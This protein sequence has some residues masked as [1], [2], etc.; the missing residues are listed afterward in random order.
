MTTRRPLPPPALSALPGRH[1]RRRFLGLAGA[2]AAGTA[3]GACRPAPTGG[4]P[5]GSDQVQLVYQD[6]R[7]EWFPAM[8][9]KE[10]ETFQQANPGIRV[11]Y[12]P[13]PDNIT[14][15][16]LADMQAGTAPDVLN[17]CCETLPAWA[18]QGYLL[19]LGPYIAAD[20]D[21]ATILDWDPAQYDALATREGV[22]FALPKYH[23]AL[24]LFYNKD[25][26]DARGVDHPDRGWT[27][28]D[29]LEA[30]KRVSSGTEDGGDGAVWG[31]MCDISWDR[32]QVYVN[33]FGGHLVDPEDPTRSRMAEPESLAGMEWL[34]ARM[35]DDRV[36]A[37]FL[38]VNNLETREAF[39]RGHL[40]MVEDGSW[41][42]K[43]ILENADFRVGVTTLPAGPV[44]RVTLATTDGFAIY[45]GTKHPEAAWELLK[46]LAGREYG[47]AMARTHLL[48][49][50]RSSL[51]EEW[52][53]TIREAY[54]RQAR[55]MDIEAFAE[56][57]V[58]GYSVTAEIF[59]NMTA[60]RE[61]A[62]AAW[63]EIFTLGR[64]PVSRM[65]AVSAEIEAAQRLGS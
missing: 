54:P 62:G 15:R 61:I 10:L 51:I 46:F 25:V 40:A 26:F 2:A 11:F 9:Q 41:A 27:H 19:D 5:H 47:R 13:D 53:A 50:A 1:S 21:Q 17:G 38:D 24:A 34:R 12:T 4:G 37:S 59:A 44:R 48:Q 32:V 58:R 64:A 36:M 60:A 52:V 30:M 65:S 22:R 31:S 8:A 16:M 42:L 29:Y 35:W 49:P 7:T 23:G 33:G 39:W 18:Q 3:V 55:D 6:W 45:A 57:H 63:E 14:E 28:D 20:L 56:G 43:D